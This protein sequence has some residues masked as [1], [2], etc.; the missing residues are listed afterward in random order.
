MKIIDYMMINAH[1][2]PEAGL[3]IIN[4]GIPASCQYY[5]G[6]CCIASAEID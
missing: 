6:S 4:S 2:I 5:T 3:V 1:A